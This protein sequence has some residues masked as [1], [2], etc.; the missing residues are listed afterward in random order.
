MMIGLIQKI[1][2]KILISKIYKDIKNIM[3]KKKSKKRKISKWKISYK[4]Y[5]MG[6]KN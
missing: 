1:Q 5:K 4:I 2:Q 3:S 6:K